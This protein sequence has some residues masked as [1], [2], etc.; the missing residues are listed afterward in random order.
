MPNFWQLATTPI[1]KIQWFTFGL[2]KLIYSEKATKFCEIS[3]LLLSIC[4]VDKSKVEISENFVAF[5]EYTNFTIPILF[6]KNW[7]TKRI[8]L[9]KRNYFFLVQL[10]EGFVFVITDSSLKSPTSK[11]EC[12]K[13][14]FN[15]YCMYI[16]WLLK[17]K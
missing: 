13:K 12:A 2:L 1:R 9:T 8:R 11:S 15:F 7:L 17:L 6:V 4:T 3:T 5:S 10:W 16:D 14:S